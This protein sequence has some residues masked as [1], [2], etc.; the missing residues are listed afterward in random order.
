MFG[1]GGDFFPTVQ[2]H[3]HGEIFVQCC[4][5]TIV[6]GSLSS[7][8]SEVCQTALGTILHRGIQFTS[9]TKNFNSTE[10]RFENSERCGQ[11]VSVAADK[12]WPRVDV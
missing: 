9:G 11:P 8:A 7:N 2:K 4:I 3:F 5:T 10:Q 12:K 1:E 6:R